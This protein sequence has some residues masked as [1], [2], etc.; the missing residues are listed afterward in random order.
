MFQDCK[1][2]NDVDT[3]VGQRDTPRFI[4]D[5]CLIDEWV[6]KHRVVGIHGDDCLAAAAEI[7][8]RPEVPADSFDLVP[9][10]SP[11]VHHDMMTFQQICDD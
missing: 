6:G 1:G 4:D 10:T 7:E 2:G 11:E 3:V 8:K 5:M 9:P